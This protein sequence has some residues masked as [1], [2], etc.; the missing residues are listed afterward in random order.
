MRYADGPTAEV[1]VTGGRAG[2]AS[3]AAGDRH[4]VCRPASPTSSREP[5][6]STANRGPGW[7]PVSGAATSTRPSERGRATSRRGGLRTGPVIR[8]GCRGSR[9]GGGLVAVRARSPTAGAAACASGPA[10]DR[11]RPGLTAAIEARPDKEERIVDRRLGEWR[12][13]MQATV[14]GI[15][16]P[17]G[18]RADPE[19]ISRRAR[20]QLRAMAAWRAIPVAMAGSS[21]TMRLEWLGAGWVYAGGAGAEKRHRSRHLLQDVGPVLGAHDRIRHPQHPLGADQGPGHG[22]GAIG[23]PV[24]VDR[25]RVVAVGDELDLGPGSCGRRPRARPPCAARRSP[26]PAMRRRRTGW[27]RRRSPTPG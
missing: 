4:R 13:N 6:G 8:L 20:T 1:E 23:G 15:K 12:R 24:V 26:G 18:V 27:C 16:S 5:S 3:V 9:R 11:V 19:L 14:D 7:A 17:G 21:I 2:G 22:E 10:W 25:Y